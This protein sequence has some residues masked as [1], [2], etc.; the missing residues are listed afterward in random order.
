MPVHGDDE[1]FSVGPGPVSGSS[2]NPSSAMI[3]E[4]YQPIEMDDGNVLRADIYRPDTDQPV[5]MIMTC[6]PYG[7]GVH[8]QDAHYKDAWDWLA[9]QHPDL[10]PGSTRSTSRRK[11]STP[12]SGFRGA[13]QW[14]GSTHEERA[15]SRGGHFDGCSCDRP[16]FPRNLRLP[17]PDDSARPRGLLPTDPPDHLSRRGHR[18]TPAGERRNWACHRLRLSGVWTGSGEEDTSSVSFRASPTR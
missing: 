6:G 5:P 16:I 17:G 13:T 9:G 11:R 12:K 2:T 1:S 4:R 18:R 10:L 7:K 3:L 8:Y 15:V 14:S